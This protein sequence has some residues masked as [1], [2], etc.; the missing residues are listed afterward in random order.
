MKG[1]LSINIPV[2]LGLK[3]DDGF[4]SDP[5]CKLTFPDKLYFS[6]KK[7]KKTLNPIF[8]F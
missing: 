2:A 7:K 8:N 6:I 3:A 5:Y 4:T 1:Q